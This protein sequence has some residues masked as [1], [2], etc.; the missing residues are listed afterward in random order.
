MCTA[1]FRAYYTSLVCHPPHCIF[2][3]PLVLAEHHKTYLVLNKL[4]LLLLVFFHPH[5]SGDPAWPDLHS[6]LH[7]HRHWHH[8]THIHQIP[9]L[10]VS[11]STSQLF[12]WFNQHIIAN[13]N[14]FTIWCKTTL[15]EAVSCGGWCYVSRL[16]WWSE[17][18]WGHW[19][20][21]WMNHHVILHWSF[22]LPSV[23][24]AFCTCIW[25]HGWSPYPV[26]GNGLCN[27]GGKI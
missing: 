18:L 2:L 23:W 21:F 9:C 1:C 6:V 27:L 8:R 17:E 4:L 24:Y 5:K 7:K 19:P 10:M 22:L 26:I 14:V 11:R 3:L 12:F 16:L 13:I 15:L 25:K 20:S